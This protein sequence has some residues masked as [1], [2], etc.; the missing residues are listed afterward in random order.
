MYAT[1]AV[2]ATSPPAAIRTRATIRSARCSRRVT[3]TAATPTPT[4]TAAE[5][6]GRL[7]VG[8]D[9]EARE[10]RGRQRE[11]G[12][13]DGQCLPAARRTRRPRAETDGEADEQGVGPAQHGRRPGPGAQPRRRAGDHQR[14]GRHRVRAGRR[15]NPVAPDP[16]VLPAR[17]LVEGVGG[18]AGTAVE[19]VAVA[20]VLDAQ[21]AARRQAYGEDHEQR[22]GEPGHDGQR[23]AARRGWC[24]GRAGHRGGVGRVRRAG[25][26]RRHDAGV[27]R[28]SRSGRRTGP[29]AARSRRR[30]G[31]A[32]G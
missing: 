18:Q 11:N 19:A 6:P 17:E 30:G 22:C 7:A 31:A 27:P 25:G 2:V 12:H 4:V 21:R 26:H 15:A 24:G 16:S 3:R 13:G 29:S 28:L 14:R 32:R 1:F 8:G 23:R 10:R 5:Q 9:E 20:V